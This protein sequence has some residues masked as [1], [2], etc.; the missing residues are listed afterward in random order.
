M[1]KRSETWL[2]TWSRPLTA[3]LAA[4]GFSLTTY[5]TVTHFLG[6]K[7]ALCNTEGSG[8]DLVLNS[9]YAKIFGIPLTVFGAA[10]YLT[11]GSLALGSFLWKKPDPKQQQAW[12]ELTGF[13]LFLGSTA[14]FVFSGYLMY[15]LA[16]GSIGGKPQFCLYCISS[17]VTMTS[18]WLITV[19]GNRWKDVGNLFF[20]GAIVALIVITGAVG[21]YGVQQRLIIQ[22][23]SFAGRLATHLKETDARMY[24]AYWC[25]HC[26]D[27]KKKFGDAAKLVPY[28][29]CDPK[30]PDPKPELCRSKGVT[31]FPTWEIGGKMY[32][33]DRSLPEL[34]DLSNYLGPRE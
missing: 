20:S 2:Q 8:C 30:G 5:L 29:E 10:A 19:F 22:G 25:P 13:L 27:Q 4:I 24:G 14:T 34:A 18:I 26:Q 12:Q 32:P 23:S 28:V 21:V 31:G 1:A 15:L 3:G 33:G 11:L 6:Q 7:V 17:A 16:S 9:E